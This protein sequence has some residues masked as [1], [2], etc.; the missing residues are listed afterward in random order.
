MNTPKARVRA[1]ALVI[2]GNEVLATYRENYGDI[3]WTFPAGGVEEGESSEEA[4]VREL[5]EEASIVGR[6]VKKITTVDSFSR[7]NR[8]G[9]PPIG[10]KAVNEVFLVEYISGTPALSPQSP[11]HAKML[12]GAEK[13]NQ[14]YT[15]QWVP[16][17]KF[18][19][20]SDVKPAELCAWM[21]TY[22]SELLLEVATD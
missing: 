2:Y 20:K 4:C 11:E 17:L 10:T 22:L 7:T 9:Y 1:V 8:P 19:E 15:P 14:V 21:H 13:G 18:L 6:V 3:Y 16:L 5:L 12:L